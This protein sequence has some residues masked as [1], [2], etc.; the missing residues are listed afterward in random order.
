MGPA[1]ELTADAM[2]RYAIEANQHQWDYVESKI[3]K[4]IYNQAAHGMFSATIWLSGDVPK[5]VLN[6]LAQ[7]L[8]NKGFLTSVVHSGFDSGWLFKVS[9]E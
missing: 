9:W 3:H 2:R 1:P 5:I 6:E 8:T 4:E 7:K